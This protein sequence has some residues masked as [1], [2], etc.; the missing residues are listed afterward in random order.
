MIPVTI[1]IYS[2][3]LHKIINTISH[4]QEVGIPWRIQARAVSQKDKRVRIRLVRLD[5]MEVRN[6]QIDP[7]TM[8]IPVNAKL[9]NVQLRLKGGGFSGLRH[10]YPAPVRNIP[11]KKKRKNVRTHLHKGR[12]ANDRTRAKTD[13]VHATVDPAG[14]EWVDG[15]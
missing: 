9:K 3:D 4:F 6:Q 12:R 7:E 2:W 11:K 15:L 8:L 5:L 1:W 14:V 10:D 13:T